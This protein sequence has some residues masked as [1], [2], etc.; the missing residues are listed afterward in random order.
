MVPAGTRYRR[1]SSTTIPSGYHNTRTFYSSTSIMVV[2]TR[3][4]TRTRTNHNNCL[5]N[6]PH[7]A[8]LRCSG[9][10]ERRRRAVPAAAAAVCCHHHHDHHHHH[11]QYFIINKKST[12]KKGASW[13][14]PKQKQIPN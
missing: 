5:P 14:R 1:T 8:P 9:W 4:R 3:T 10:S 2:F 7:I 12:S 13:C 6:D 11:H